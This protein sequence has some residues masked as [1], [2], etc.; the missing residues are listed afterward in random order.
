MMEQR[1]ADGTMRRS[2]A[3]MSSSGMP[4]PTM[5]P[6]CSDFS[7]KADVLRA[8]VHLALAQ[9]I[10]VWEPPAL[11]KSEDLGALLFRHERGNAFRG[12]AE[13]IQQAKHL[14]HFHVYTSPLSIVTDANTQTAAD[15]QGGTPTLAMHSDAGLLL[16]FTAPLYDGVGQQQSGLW[17]E[18]QDKTVEMLELPPDSLAL[19]V[20]EAARWLPWPTRPVPHAL[21]LMR[22]SVRAWYGQMLRLPGDAVRPDTFDPTHTQQHTFGEWWG[23]LTQVGLH[24]EGYQPLG[25]LGCVPVGLVHGQDALANMAPECEQGQSFCWMMCMQVPEAC[26]NSSVRTTPQ[27]QD[28]NGVDWKGGD[29]MCPD[30]KWRCKAELGGDG[31][32]DKSS[33]VD[34]MMQGFV[35]YGFTG[36]PDSSCLV[37]FFGSWV[38]DTAGKFWAA[39]F[40]VLLL[41]MAVEYGGPSPCCDHGPSTRVGISA[42]S[43]TSGFVTR[44]LRPGL[45][46]TVQMALAYLAM[47]ATMTFS[48]E[49]FCAVVLGLGL[50]RVVAELIAWCKVPSRTSG[51][52][53][54]APQDSE[55]GGVGAEL[56]ALRVDGMT[57]SECTNAVERALRT[58]PGVVH[59]S[60]SL[61]NGEGRAEVRLHDRMVRSLLAAV[62]TVGFTAVA[63]E[64]D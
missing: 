49:M 24:P 55:L 11:N 64:R 38:L 53:A 1:L 12:L 37:L 43:G 22:G 45:F 9:V 8:L 44:V 58:V 17:V 15:P 2:I 30:C 18:T 39:W 35:T 41:G 54:D 42:P 51:R 29:N 10:R 20:G 32:C 47:L 63:L 25:S 26:V 21:R 61:E 19:M 60:V 34:M 62:E 56:I 14:E 6:G 13:A 4:E 3:A 16:A 59:V 5:V 40:G 28:S 36:N 7:A 52:V 50:G 27:C 57:C 33:A 23:N 46:R 31:F 48:V